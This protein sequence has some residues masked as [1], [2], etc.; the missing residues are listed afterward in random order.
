MNNKCHIVRDLLPSYIDDLCSK[1]SRQFIEEHVASCSTCRN[2]LHTM[3]HNVEV[4]EGIEQTKRLEAKKP[5]KKVAEFF[6]AQRRLT[7]YILITALISLGLGICF[8]ANSM[9]KLNEYKNEVN[10]LEMVDHEKEDIMKDVFH[11][12]GA[13]SEVTEQEEEQL[14]KVFEKYK[15]KLHLLAVFPAADVEDWVKENPSVKKEPTTIYPIEYNKAAA[16]IG[17]EGIFGRNKQI[18]PSQYDLGTVAMANSKWVIQYE[19]K[20]SYEKTVERHHQLK[21]YGQSV[22]SFFQLPILLFAIF[23]VLLIVWLFLKKHNKHLK[24]VMG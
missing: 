17:S 12:L 8:L 14:L 21:Y 11:V 23:S 9:V 20:S 6:N 7:K 13:S 24:D 2:V 15:E 3:E 4:S 10:K 18:I 16:V 5:F 1:E 19:Y 22:W